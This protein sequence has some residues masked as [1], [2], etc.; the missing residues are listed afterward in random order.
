[1]L[2]ASLDFPGMRLILTRTNRSRR[3][4][5]RLRTGDGGRPLRSH[6]NVGLANGIAHLTCA[7]NA[8]SPVVILNERQVDGDREPRRFTT[9]RSS[10]TTCVSSSSAR[11][12]R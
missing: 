2:D 8:H 11:A 1:V 9:S 3:G 10:K 4:R 5:R 12:S 6:A 7:S